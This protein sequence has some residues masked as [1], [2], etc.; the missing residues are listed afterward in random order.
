MASSAG[1]DRGFFNN[2][3]SKNNEKVE[4]KTK[5]QDPNPNDFDDYGDYLAAKKKKE[6]EKE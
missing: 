6:E 4:N 3:G 5:E 1:R 2:M